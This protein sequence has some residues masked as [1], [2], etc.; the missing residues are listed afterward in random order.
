MWHAMVK[1]EEFWTIYAI[2]VL[3]YL[4]VVLILLGIQYGK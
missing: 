3:F 4:I 2:I 1:S